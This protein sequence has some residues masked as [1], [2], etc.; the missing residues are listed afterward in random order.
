MTE[1]SEY[2]LTMAHPSYQP[3]K[4]LPIPGTERRD[5]AGRLL[6]QD[7]QGTPEKFAPVTVADAEQQAYYEA[8]G[9][10]P[11]GHS[12]PSAYAAAHASAPP[13]DYAPIEYPKWV[14]AVLV[15]SAEE[16]AALNPVEVKKTPVRA[17]QA[18]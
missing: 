16:E 1:H 2:P 12:D 15:N 9:Y 4:A 11:A 5:A 14:G 10:A 7:Y 6:S 13:P 18:A 3:S 8:Q 17:Q